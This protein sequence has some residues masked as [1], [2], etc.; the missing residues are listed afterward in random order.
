MSEVIKFRKHVIGNIKAKTINDKKIN[1][2]MYYSMLSS[3]VNA[4]NDGAVPNIE[5]AWMYMCREQSNRLLNE[6]LAIFDAKMKEVRIPS[7]EDFFTK[8]CDKA[9]EAALD[10][11]KKS[12]IGDDI[13]E[14]WKELNHKIKE[15]IEGFK[16]KNER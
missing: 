4:I 2:E 16:Q 10:A 9:I 6:S 11:Y 12:L 3:Y 1:G 13:P 7:N 5:N 15:K 14:I 8:E